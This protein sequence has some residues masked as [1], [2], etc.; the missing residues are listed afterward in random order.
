MV[1]LAPGVRDV[2]ALSGAAG[3]AGGA[4]DALG[5]AEEPLAAAEVERKTPTVE[6]GGHEPGLAGEQAGLGGGDQVAGVE[7]G[8]PH[9]AAEDVEVEGDDDRRGDPAVE[10]VGREALEQLAE[11]EAAGVGR[12]RG[13]RG[14][15]AA[16]GRGHRVEDLP[17]DGGGERRDPEVAAGGAV[18]VV[19]QGQSRLREGGLLLVD[20]LLV[21][22]GVDHGPVLLHGL[23]RSPGDAAELDRVEPLRSVDE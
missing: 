21:L 18:A 1:E 7:S 20:E 12:V 5:L 23:E 14:R 19:V 6:D 11:R 15:A 3:V 16:S 8:R 4:C 17:E 10:V 13:H 22:V 2:A 9:L